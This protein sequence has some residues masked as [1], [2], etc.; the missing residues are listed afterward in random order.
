MTMTKRTDDKK[1][2]ATPDSAI[3]RIQEATLGG[4]DGL[5]LTWPLMTGYRKA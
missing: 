3:G 4:W 2:R 1:T 5:R